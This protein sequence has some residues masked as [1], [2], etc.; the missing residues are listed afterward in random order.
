MSTSPSK[1]QGPSGRGALSPS[2][3]Q[4]ECPGLGS[5]CWQHLAGATPEESEQSKTLFPQKEHHG[6]QGPGLVTEPVP[7]GSPPPTSFSSG[8]RGVWTPL[9]GH[10][11]FFAHISLHSPGHILSS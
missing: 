5:A 6:A 7:C 8:Q 4:H 11:P 2:V 1:A 9:S 3:P 10:C